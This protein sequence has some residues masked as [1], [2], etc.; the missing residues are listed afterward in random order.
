VSRP[1][2]FTTTCTEVCNIAIFN[3]PLI[4]SI[5]KV[6]STTYDL[7]SLVNTCAGWTKSYTVVL[8][9]LTSLV[10]TCAW[11]TNS[12]TVVLYDLTSLVNTCA[13]WTKSY[14]VVLYDLTSLVN[15]CAWWTILSNSCAFCSIDFLSF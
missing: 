8:Y 13:W 6:F 4:F 3:Y 15:T 7:T 9:D 14:T 1:I 12:Y 2:C 5:S 10:N 11:W